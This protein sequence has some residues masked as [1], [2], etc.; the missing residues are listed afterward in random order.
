MLVLHLNGCCEELFFFLTLRQCLT[1]NK[2]TQHRH[3]QTHSHRRF[4]N[5]FSET[6]EHIKHSLQSVISQTLHRLHVS[7]LIADLGYTPSYLHVKC[8]FDHYFCNITIVWTIRMVTPLFYPCFFL[9]FYFSATVTSR[10][11]SF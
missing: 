4:L 2:K 6:L 5:I 11:V 3:P 10:C 7:A 9:Y 8:Y 1:S